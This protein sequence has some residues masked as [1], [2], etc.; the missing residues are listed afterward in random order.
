[1]PQASA[2]C[3]CALGTEAMAGDSGVDQFLQVFRT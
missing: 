2:R 1:M 3:F